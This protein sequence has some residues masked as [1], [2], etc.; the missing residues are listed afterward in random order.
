MEDQSLMEEND[1]VHDGKSGMANPAVKKVVVGVGIVLAAGLLMMCA[2][3]MGPERQAA[4][5]RAMMGWTGKSCVNTPGFQ[6]CLNNNY[7]NWNGF[8]KCAQPSAQS[9]Y[10]TC[11]NVGK[12]LSQN[13]YGSEKQ[14]YSSE[15]SMVRGA[16]HNYCRVLGKAKD[17]E[18][19]C[20]KIMMKRLPAERSLWACATGAKNDLER[21]IGG[22]TTAN[23]FEAC[24][25]GAEAA[26]DTFYPEKREE[27]KQLC[28]D[29][30]S[31]MSRSSVPKT[32][33]W[34]DE[35]TQVQQAINMMC[36]QDDP[37]TA[38]RHCKNVKQ[39]YQVPDE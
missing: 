33:D 29:A 39:K 12:K 9:C 3:G 32:R 23:Q 38:E 2:L 34:I 10:K 7:G 18:L 28:R 37:T 17:T 35:F 27:C 20:T 5:N 24:I 4:P 19:A 26:L 30:A 31:V 21:C 36:P 22:S 14:M 1:E 13:N 16:E 15:M 8:K 11:S 25:G 6:E